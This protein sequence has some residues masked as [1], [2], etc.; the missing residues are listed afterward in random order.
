[1][2]LSG[3]ALNVKDQ[4][5]GGAS[6]PSNTLLG[7]FRC[8]RL[9]WFGGRSKRKGL[10]IRAFDAWVAFF[11]QPSSSEGVWKTGRHF[12]WQ[13]SSDDRWKIK[14]AGIVRTANFLPQCPS[15]AKPSGV[16]RTLQSPTNDLP[17]IIL[18]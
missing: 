15:S 6:G 8:S 16:A 12:G 18:A 10:M 3:A 11:A 7:T 4:E 2:I 13:G 5:L 14:V 1:M 17:P 9:F